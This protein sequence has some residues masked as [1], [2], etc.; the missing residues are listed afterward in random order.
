LAP[1]VPARDDPLTHPYYPLKTDSEW[2]YKVQGG[3]IKVKVVGTEKA[4]GVTGFKLETSAGGKVSATETV[5]VMKEGV[6][7]LNVNGITP[8]RPILFL[9]ADPDATKEWVVNSKAG[10]QEIK[11]TF[12][13]DREKVTV[14]AGTY[15]TIH[16]KGADFTIGAGKSTVE[17]W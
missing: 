10:G 6:H 13:V 14:P 5:A 9:P 1:A 7:R 17:Y 15:E 16:V 11:G 8:H 2:T 12:K 3:P 4:G